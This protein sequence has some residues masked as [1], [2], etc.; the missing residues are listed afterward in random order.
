[1]KKRM[2]NVVGLYDSIQMTNES[3][4]VS[5]MNAPVIKD[6]YDPLSGLHDGTITPNAPIVVIGEDLCP[7]L[8]GKV[9]WGLSPA[10]DKERFIEIRKIYKYTDIQLLMLLPKLEPGEY[11]LVMKVCTE[12]KADFIYP[13]PILPWRVVEEKEVDMFAGAMRRSSRFYK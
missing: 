1:M 9:H 11:F 3:S 5:D 6:M 12:N 8:P 2:E 7:P 10:G 4:V 13:L